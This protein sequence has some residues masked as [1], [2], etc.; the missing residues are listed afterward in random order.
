MGGLS[1]IT[2][3]KDFNQRKKGKENDMKL[4][5]LNWLIRKFSEEKFYSSDKICS[6]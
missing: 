5:V 3:I 6:R 2:V 4:A 1:N